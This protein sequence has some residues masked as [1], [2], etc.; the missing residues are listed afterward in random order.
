MFDDKLKRD[1]FNYYY[2]DG[3]LSICLTF[4]RFGNVGVTANFFQKSFESNPSKAVENFISRYYEEHIFPD[5][6]I[7]PFEYIP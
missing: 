3:I 5:E 2:Q 7:T 1:I 6:I 4:V